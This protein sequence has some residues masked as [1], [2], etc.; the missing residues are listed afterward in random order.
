MKEGSSIKS[1]VG[2]GVGIWLPVSKISPPRLPAPGKHIDIS[3]L[4]GKI[5]WVPPEVS[6]IDVV[7]YELKL[8]AALRKSVCPSMPK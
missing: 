3:N 1:H 5:G 6:E 2:V 8:V 4:I 7:E